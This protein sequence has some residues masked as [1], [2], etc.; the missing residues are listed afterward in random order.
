MKINK[1]LNPEEREM[2]EKNGV[3]FEEGKEPYF[4]KKDP[5]S[6]PGTLRLSSGKLVPF[7][8]IECLQC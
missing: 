5:V 2:L 7:T 3:V 6:P 4:A 1:E 8:P